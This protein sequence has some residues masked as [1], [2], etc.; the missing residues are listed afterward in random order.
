M[1]YF[2]TKNSKKTNTHPALKTDLFESPTHPILDLLQSGMG[3]GW[4]R[5]W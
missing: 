5:S 2:P 4:T 1:L 3:M